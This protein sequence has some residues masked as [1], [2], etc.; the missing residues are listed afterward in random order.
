[1]KVNL[2]ILQQLHFESQIDR[3][4]VEI[5]AIESFWRIEKLI[6]NDIFRE[7]LSKALLEPDFVCF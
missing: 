3:R 4:F 2:L 5:A 6:F 7:L 1:M